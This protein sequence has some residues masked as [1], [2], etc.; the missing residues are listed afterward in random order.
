MEADQWLSPRDLAEMFGLPVRTVYSWRT[1]GE[2]P[3]GY[4]VGKHIRFRRS[5]VELWLAERAD[6]PRGAA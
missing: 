5:D 3:M 2:G 6:A 4:R 1:R